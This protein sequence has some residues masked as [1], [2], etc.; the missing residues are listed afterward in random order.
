MRNVGNID[1]VC[2]AFAHGIAGPMRNSTGSVFRDGEYI[3]S[4]GRHFPM[5]RRMAHPRTGAPL[6]LVS[7]DSYSVTTTHQQGRVARAIPSDANVFY[8][9]ILDIEQRLLR[10]HTADEAMLANHAENYESYRKRVDDGLASA[11]RATKYG[12][13]YYASALRQADAARRYCEAF[14]YEPPEPI[15]VPNEDKIREHLDRIK[16]REEKLARE[17]QERLVK[18]NE[19][20]IAKWRRG[21]RATLPMGIPPLLRTDGETVYTS[22]SASFPVSH[23][24]RAWRVISMVIRRG[25][26]WVHNES[27]KT[28]H[29]GHFAVDY[30]K[31]DGTVKAGCHIVAGEEVIRLARDLELEIPEEVTS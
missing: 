24:K 13:T 21:E 7:T 16:R 8:V 12:D 5:A 3:Y 20:M 23:A 29:L 17:R 27:D 25:R 2:H 19:D 31:E 11:L 18:E 9:P 30:I 4:Y 15:T 28:I 1:E 6:F 26:G 22:W 14:G 10:G